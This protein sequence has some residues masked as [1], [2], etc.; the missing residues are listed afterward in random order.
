MHNTVG[1]LPGG[2]TPAG[3]GY[4]FAEHAK[5]TE[6][7]CMAVLKVTADRIVSQPPGV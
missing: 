1:F 4:G 7:G 2:L 5:L 3:K 6:L